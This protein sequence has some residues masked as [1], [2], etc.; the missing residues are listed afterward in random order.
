VSHSETTVLG[1]G[2]GGWR[3]PKIDTDGA[4]SHDEFIAHQ[5]K[6]F[7]MMDI[8]NAGSL[9]PRESLAGGTSSAKQ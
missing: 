7:D 6:V 5:S 9:G 3:L 1:R 4:V 2:C 8:R